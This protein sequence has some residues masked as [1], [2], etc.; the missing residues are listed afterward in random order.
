M[1]L[2]LCVLLLFFLVCSIAFADGVS[3][4]GVL[5]DSHNQPVNGTDISLRS[6]D[7]RQQYSVTTSVDGT[8]SVANLVL[9]DYEVRVT[10]SGTDYAATL[11]IRLCAS[12]VPDFRFKQ[13]LCGTQA[14]QDH[15]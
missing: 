10:S 13:L 1:F 12:C 3:W 15:E 11:H 7:G 4:G 8:F 2:R 14:H 9:G 6:S 5:R